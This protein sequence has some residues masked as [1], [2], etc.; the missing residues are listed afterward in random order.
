MINLKKYSD[1]DRRFQKEIERIEWL[2]VSAF[3]FSFAALIISIF[4]R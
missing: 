3:L 2:A 1:L 4:V